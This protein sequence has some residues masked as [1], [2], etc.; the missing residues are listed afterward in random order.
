MHGPEERKV[1]S[2][3]EL[4]AAIEPPR[5]LW[6]EIEARLKAPA[7]TATPASRRPAGARLAQLR[8]LAA[9]AMVAS[10]AVG[11]WI[12]REVLPLAGG[13][14]APPQ[15]AAVSGSPANPK[16]AALNASYVSD[17]RYQRQRTELLKSLQ[18]RIEA[19]PAPARL[20]V[21]AS[22][23]TIEHAKEDLERALGKD[24]SNAL[25]QELLI[26]TYQDEMRA[27]TDVHEAS[28]PGRGI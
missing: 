13:A 18:A 14:G 6:P 21:T 16:G 27:L 24:P 26:N 10:V 12:G 28:E 4:P 25:L 19:M 11:V 2:L 8:W 5:D 7:A 3:G 17:P 15:S 20:K 9:A 1:K 23:A 22:L